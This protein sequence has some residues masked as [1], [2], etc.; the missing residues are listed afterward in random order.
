M[1]PADA[2]PTQGMSPLDELRAE[3]AARRNG[4]PR[5]LY[6]R[7]PGGPGILVAEY[8]VINNEMV[9]ETFES[10]VKLDQDADLLI[11]ALVDIHVAAP[12]H[13]L[14]DERGLVQFSKWAQQDS[15]GPLG[16]D[17]RLAEAIGI[18]PGSA[19]E[20]CLALFDGNE[21]ALGAQSAVVSAWMVDTSEEALQDFTVGSST[22]RL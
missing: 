19:R 4:A 14:A 18:E 6:K 10:D 15:G 12:K 8:K 13:E 21:I 22:A 20:I 7:L 16:F 9:E 2:V 5:R 3:F 1:S 17:Q 11:R